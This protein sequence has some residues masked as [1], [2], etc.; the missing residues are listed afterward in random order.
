MGQGG[1]V[2]RGILTGAALAALLA[3]GG[4]AAAAPGALA[5]QL[6][7]AAV[8][9]QVTAAVKLPVVYTQGMGET[10]AAPK[11]KPG[12][13][14]FGADTE[15]DQLHWTH[16]TTRSAFA[17]GQWWACAGAQGP[18]QKWSGDVALTRVASHHGTKYFSW[19]VITAKHH[20]TITYKYTATGQWQ[21]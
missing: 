14:V 7:P 9:G 20:K 18:C 11:V 2:V 15:A 5:A 10:W 13:I 1:T 16:W 12:A 21:A 8:A 4:T 6:K 3:A 19:L 17:S